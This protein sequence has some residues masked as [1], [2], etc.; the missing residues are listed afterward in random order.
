M[1]IKIRA[2]TASAHDKKESLDITAAVAIQC[3]IALSTVGLDLQ[4]TRC[5]MCSLVCR[6]S[7]FGSREPKFEY[8]PMCNKFM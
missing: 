6:L 1:F 3:A 8:G 2:L 4:Y 5:M 7:A